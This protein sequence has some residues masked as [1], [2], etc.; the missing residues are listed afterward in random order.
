MTDNSNSTDTAYSA[1]EMTTASAST[2]TAPAPKLAGDMPRA[3][4]ELIDDDGDGGPV[5]TANGYSVATT[6][7]FAGIA[8]DNL[9]APAVL[10]H[11]VEDEQGNRRVEARHRDAGISTERAAELATYFAGFYDL[12]HDAMEPG[13]LIG[14]YEDLRDPDLDGNPGLVESFGVLGPDAARTDLDEYVRKHEQRQD[15]D[16]TKT[17]CEHGE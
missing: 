15:R 14:I 2:E 9:D 16:D 17:R 5:R 1:D 11:V 10:F 13:T 8:R 3:R 4:P 7:A 12:D 6:G